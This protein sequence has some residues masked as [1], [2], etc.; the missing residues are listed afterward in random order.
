MLTRY[1]FLGRIFLSSIQ[2]YFIGIRKV[3]FSSGKKGVKPVN[4]ETQMTDY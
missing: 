3:K 2:G 4:Q 1:N